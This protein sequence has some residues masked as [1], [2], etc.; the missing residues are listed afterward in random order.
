MWVGFYI[1]EAKLNFGT[2]EYPFTVSDIFSSP[3]AAASLGQVYKLRLKE[4]G[5]L[6]GLKVQ[7]LDMHHSVLR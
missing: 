2:T 6:I 1:K 5:S 3:I 7:R 4:D